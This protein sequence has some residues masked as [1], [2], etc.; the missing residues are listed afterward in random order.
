MASLKVEI[1]SPVLVEDKKKGERPE[2]P[3][4]F[5]LPRDFPSS[6]KYYLDLYRDAMGIVAKFGKPDL[7]ITITANPFL[8]NS[9]ISS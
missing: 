8:A 9:A 5:S 1:G 3:K 7:F 6:K 4:I 2:M